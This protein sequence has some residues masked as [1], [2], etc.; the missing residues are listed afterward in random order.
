MKNLIKRSLVAA[1][2]FT[3]LLGYGKDVNPKKRIN[4][5]NL[6][7]LTLKH[8]EKGN[9]LLVKDLKGLVLYK[10]T[11]QKSGV[12][13]KG[14]DLTEL[15]NGTYFFEL[16]KTLKTEII[17]FEVEN[18]KAKI[19]KK[20]SDVVYKPYVRFNNDLIYLSSLSLNKSPLEIEIYYTSDDLTFEGK[21]YSETIKNTSNIQKAYKLDK[22]RTGTY[23]IV[24]NTEGKTFVEYTKF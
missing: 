15:P 2:L 1:V 7:T 12:Y 20:D 13:L 16:D 14:F 9:Q 5:D 24:L 17:P 3:A 19:N 11:I 22:T 18:Q 10:E 4:D 23:K 8:V 6:T 21:I